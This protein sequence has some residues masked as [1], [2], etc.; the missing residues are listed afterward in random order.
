MGSRSTT[1]LSERVSAQPPFDRIQWRWSAL[2]AFVAWIE[3]TGMPLVIVRVGGAKPA[4]AAI[5]E[6]GSCL[7]A[8]FIQAGYSFAGGLR[9]CAGMRGRRLCF[10]D[11]TYRAIVR[12]F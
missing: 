9:G 1:S 6:D 11:Y 5:A 3:A 10:H 4:L 7:V 8:G 2:A 12:L